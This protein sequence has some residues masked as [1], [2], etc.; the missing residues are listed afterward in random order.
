MT[1]GGVNMEVELFDG[2]D[3]ARSPPQPS[4][5][6]TAVI[7]S[8]IISATHVTPEYGTYGD[9]GQML[10]SFLSTTIAPRYAHMCKNKA[11]FTQ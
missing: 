3:E 1:K 6:S 4:T 9:S 8:N 5:V 7:D 2:F 11:H 10:S